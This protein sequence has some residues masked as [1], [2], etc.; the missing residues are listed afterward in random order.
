MRDAGE[1]KPG[2]SPGSSATPAWERGGMRSSVHGLRDRAGRTGAIVGIPRILATDLVRAAPEARGAG[3]LAA[4]ERDRAA[5]GDGVAVGRE[6]D[7]ARRRAG[8]AHHGGG[9]RHVVV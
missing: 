4:G 9:E 1:K 8:V 7:G 6:V 3:G 5:T 2:T